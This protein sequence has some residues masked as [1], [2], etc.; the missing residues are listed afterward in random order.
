[1]GLEYVSYT[2]KLSSEFVQTWQTTTGKGKDALALG[3]KSS[4]P[5]SDHTSSPGSVCH[6]GD[7]QD[8]G[9]GTQ[10]DPEGIKCIACSLLSEQRSSAAHH[11][12]QV[13]HFL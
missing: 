6:M 1:M 3:P 4:I 13:S 5:S 10:T 8:M 7:A 2:V 9:R 11:S 12:E